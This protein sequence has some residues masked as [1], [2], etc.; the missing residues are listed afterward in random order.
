[1]DMR[2]NLRACKCPRAH[3]MSTNRFSIQGD[4][5]W[6]PDRNC[7]S[8]TRW[9]ISIWNKCK[10]HTFKVDEDVIFG[11]FSK[12]FIISQGLGRLFILK[13]HLKK[14]SSR[15]TLKTH[16]V[17]LMSIEK[18]HKNDF[19]RF[20]LWWRILCKNQ[21]LS[22][23]LIFFWSVSPSTVNSPTQAKTARFLSYG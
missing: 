7:G 4:N 10:N 19:F 20:W 18:S 12:C 22:N 21:N 1:M 9:N 5:F 13:S 6:Y 17:Y 3:L 8:K 23:P 16:S 15:V 14:W 2:R 11:Y